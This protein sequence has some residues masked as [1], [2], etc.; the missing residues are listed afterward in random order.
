MLEESIFIRNLGVFPAASISETIPTV[1]LIG[2]VVPRRK[3]SAPTHAPLG[4][5]LMSRSTD[6]CRMSRPFTFNTFGILDKLLIAE[7][8]FPIKQFSIA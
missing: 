2:S 7:V 5:P 1:E 8:L 6:V 4:N 3:V